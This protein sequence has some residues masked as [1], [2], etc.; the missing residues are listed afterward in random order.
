M[1]ITDS[2]ST[3]RE[4]LHERTGDLVAA[5]PLSDPQQ[6][7]LNIVMESDALPAGLRAAFRYLAQERLSDSFLPVQERITLPEA[8]EDPLYHSLI[9][10]F[11]RLGSIPTDQFYILLDTAI[12][13]YLKYLAQPVATLA[14]IVSQ[15]KDE[16]IL[17]DHFD[18]HLSAF[19]D[20][21]YLPAIILA[22][23]ERQSSFGFDSCS[24]DNFNQILHS[25]E[26]TVL[27]ATSIRRLEEYLSPLFAIRED[28]TCTSELLAA[29]F[30]EKGLYTVAK[31]VLADRST[32]TWQTLEKILLDLLLV[33]PSS[34]TTEATSKETAERNES[35]P[36]QMWQELKAI[37]VV[38]PP[39][40]RS[41]ETHRKGAVD[42]PS[43]FSEEKEISV[44]P[45]VQPVNSEVI[46]E[47]ANDDVKETP[48]TE[49]V[50]PRPVLT[51]A[52]IISP[53]AREKF[54]RKLFNKSEAN[55][56]RAI[57]LL[58]SAVNWKEASIYLDAFFLRNKID[59]F[60]KY[61]L[62]LSDLVYQH[63]KMQSLNN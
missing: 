49:P 18:H 10:G 20:Y 16:V 15:G 12:D 13:L 8:L 54:I 1:T 2:L 42:V 14:D 63:L 4:T 56:E 50:Q 46:E 57:E 45:A 62:R 44:K 52:D 59:P 31:R 43:T 30:E 37:G 24:F 9:E 6:I 34:V 27:R 11:L 53:E 47:A 29:Y 22:W 32:H 51:L 23:K 48:S 38:I 41:R 39:S 28:H 33:E 21:P 19:I 7:P 55:Y 35:K 3:L 25:T 60:S 61:A 40:Q 36:P 5:Q 26:E 17:D 58:N